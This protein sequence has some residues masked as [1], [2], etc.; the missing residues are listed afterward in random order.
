MSDCVFCDIVA[1]QAPAQIIER[2]ADTFAFMDINPATDGHL[3]VIPVRHVTDIWEATGDELAV[4]GQTTHRLAEVIRTALAP[5]GLNLLQCNG[6]AAF[7][8]VFHLHTHLIPRWTTDTIS[9]PWVPAPGDPARI[10]T[11]ADRI[12]AARD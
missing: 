5:D 12:R 4:M 2:T 7:Q 3:L 10:A 8:S 11:V 1:D 9:L 6:V